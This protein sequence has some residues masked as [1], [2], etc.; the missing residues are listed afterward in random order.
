MVLSVV[1][2]WT[3]G[4]G[5]CR[6]QEQNTDPRTRRTHSVRR[7][8][9]VV[10]RKPAVTAFFGGAAAGFLSY[11]ALEGMGDHAKEQDWLFPFF[12]LGLPL[13][14]GVLAALWACYQRRGQHDE[15]VYALA[16][17]AVFGWGAGFALTQ[18]AFE[19]APLGNAV[20]GA[21][22]LSIVAALCCRGAIT[23]VGAGGR[24]LERRQTPT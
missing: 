12:F 13:L 3:G 17:W 16:L 10:V 4:A 2:A 21:V 1:K 19:D 11:L 8:V 15:K 22:I 23:L 7:V 5:T 6:K 18:T 24:W 14:V 20:G 9:A